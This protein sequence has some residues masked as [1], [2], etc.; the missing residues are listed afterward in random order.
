[1]QINYAW[2]YSALMCYLLL[3]WR[4]LLEEKLKELREKIDSVDKRLLE[5]IFE[6]SSLVKDIAEVKSV[7]G[8]DILRPGREINLLNKLFK[9][10]NVL[11]T[12]DS[13]L[14][15]WREIISTITN[16]VQ[17]SFEL[18]ITDSAG[19]DLSNE[20]R[21][22]Y[23]SKTKK[24]FNISHDEAIRNVS[25]SKDF[26]AA[27]SAKGDWWTK[28]LPKNVNIFGSLPIIYKNPQGFL[29]GQVEPE[30]AIN[31]KTVL[32]C[33]EQE[34]EALK[35][36]YKIKVLASISGSFLILVEGYFKSF[37]N[38]KVSILGNFGYIDA[39]S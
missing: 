29:I 19:S 9:E 2:L 30:K 7:K 18:L 31:N 22:F 17:S 6:R 20:V 38:N 21:N 24:T 28:E 35:E 8:V 34:K 3:L 4:M 26:I 32:I 10:G 33:G 12:G 25:E 15:I 36:Q 14:N 23:G 27:I 13:I 5:L 16:S 37:E 1:M 11:L 39:G